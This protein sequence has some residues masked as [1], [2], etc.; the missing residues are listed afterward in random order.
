MSL[1]AHSVPDFESLARAD[2]GAMTLNWLRVSMIATRTRGCGLDQEMNKQ[3][4]YAPLKVALQTWLCG[5]TGE[6]PLLE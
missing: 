4:D 2:A 6:V 5:R 3:I 1:E